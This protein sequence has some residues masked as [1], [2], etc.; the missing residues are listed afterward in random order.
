MH[1]VA[2]MQQAQEWPLSPPPPPQQQAAP[3]AAAGHISHA[4]RQLYA[5]LH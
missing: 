2:S 3:L 4:L 5:E 1:A